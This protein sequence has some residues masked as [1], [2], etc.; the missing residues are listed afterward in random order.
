MFCNLCISH[1]YFF[2][3]I[4]QTISTT[5]VACT[6]TFV[7]FP[8]FISLLLGICRC[9]VIIPWHFTSSVTSSLRCDVCVCYTGPISGPKPHQLTKR[10]LF[11]SR[12]RRRLL[13][14][15]ASIWLSHLQFWC[16]CRAVRLL[17]C[18]RCHTTRSEMT[19]RFLAAAARF[20]L[21]TNPASIDTQDASPW[22]NQT[23]F[24]LISFR[25]LFQPF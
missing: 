10:R 18:V 25:S 8:F 4:C 3:W 23:W 20:F 24:N 13:M 5:F 2:S 22:F 9:D 12:H 14:E 16:V 11:T 19:I 7:S 15:F 1:I 17:A 21:P 6:A